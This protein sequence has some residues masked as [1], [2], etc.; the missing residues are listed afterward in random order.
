MWVID[1][2]RFFVITCD[3]VGV[4]FRVLLRCKFKAF[5]FQV[6]AG[7]LKARI[8]IF[9]FDRMKIITATATDLA[10]IKPRF[11]S[12]KCFDPLQGY[13]VAPKQRIYRIQLLHAYLNIGK[14]D[15]ICIEQ[16]FL[17]RPMLEVNHTK[18]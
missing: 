11:F 8:I 17:R 7:E 1:H 3:P 16:L 12:V 14:R 18:Q 2:Y 4:K 13:I 6:Y 5:F 9:L 10:Y 15:I